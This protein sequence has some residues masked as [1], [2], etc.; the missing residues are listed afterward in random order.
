MDG[1]GVVRED[2]P[3]S[4]VANSAAVGLIEMETEGLRV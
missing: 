2:K 3:K 4:S 1:I